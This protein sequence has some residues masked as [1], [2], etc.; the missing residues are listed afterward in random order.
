MRDIGQSGSADRLRWLAIPI[1]ALLFTAMPAC[2]S[3]AP[4]DP[5]QR[6]NQGEE[7]DSGSF[8]GR[9]PEA[10]SAAISEGDATTATSGCNHVVFCDKPNNAI[11]T[12]CHQ[13]A[14]CGLL[15]AELECLADLRSLGCELHCPAVI[16]T[17]SGNR[18]LCLCCAYCGPGG[19]CCD[20]VHFSAACPPS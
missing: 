16:E 4:E 18:P 2:S 9:V 7:A 11:G 20:G 5:S 14:G 1:L 13:E 19:A 17:P 15:D 3:T 6:D 8:Q 12:V 10:E